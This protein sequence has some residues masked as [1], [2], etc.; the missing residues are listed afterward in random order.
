MDKLTVF[1]AQGQAVFAIASR[2]R[3]EGQTAKAA[4]F[5]FH[6]RDCRPN[7]NACKAGVPKPAGWDK[8][9]YWW[10]PSDAAGTARASRLAHHA[11]AKA[12]ARLQHA[13]VTEEQSRATD[14]LDIEIPVP[15]GLQYYGYQRAGIVFALAREG[16]L[17]GDDMGLGKTAQTLGVVNADPTCR[18]VLVICPAS[19]RINW[20]REACRWLVRKTRIHVIDAD[21]R[22]P[23]G[24]V[25]NG[26][27]VTV[28]PDVPT[29]PAIVVVNYDR[30]RRPEVFKALMAHAWDVVAC[31]EA[32]FLKNPKSQRAVAILGKPSRKADGGTPGLYSRARR[33]MALTGTPMPNKTIEM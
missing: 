17:I 6:G 29:D 13:T 18:R 24:F 5:W 8:P 31:D 20:L 26:H 7:C 32:H 22:L 3:E 11:D 9:A 1:E 28:G 4:G 12:S 33:R 15:A 10:T 25:P 19:L 2:N 23:K 14:R 30:V 16:V 21:V 27:A